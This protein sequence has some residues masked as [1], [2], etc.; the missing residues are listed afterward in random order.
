MKQGG[1]YVPFHEQAREYLANVFLP[2]VSCVNYNFEPKQL[3]I[4]VM[5]RRLLIAST[6]KK[7]I[8]DKDYYGNKRLE[9][10]G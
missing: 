2:H 1:K 3:F 8:D 9:C 5:V 10:A 7:R 6:D 4:A